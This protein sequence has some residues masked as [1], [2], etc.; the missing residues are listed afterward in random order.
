MPS[1]AELVAI[2]ESVEKKYLAQPG[3]TGIDVGYKVVGGVQ[4]D[5]V[6]I[7]VHVEEKKK[8]VP[9]GQQVPAQIDGVVTDVLERRYELQVTRAPL[10]VS[11]LADTT[12]YA[13]LEGGISMGPSRAIG[14]YVFAGT[15]G[16]IVTDEASGQKAAVT[17]FHVACVDDGWSVG[18]RQVQ[19]SRVDTGVPPGDEFGAI[20]RAVLSSHVDGAVVSIDAGRTTAQ[21][22]VDIGTVNGTKPAALGMEVRKRGRTTGLTYG[23]V[24]G[25]ALSVSVDYGD[26]L[27]VHVL[28]GQV[29]IATDTTK[30]PLFSD[31]GDS[32]S[33][34]VDSTG[35]VVALLFAGA[36]TN[37]VGNPVADVLSELNISIPMGKSI[38]KDVKD[39]HKDIIKDK[40]KELR[41]DLI[42]DKE[43][44]KE[45]IKDKEL[46]KELIAD[47][48]RIKDI[49]DVIKVPDLPPIDPGDPGDPGPGLPGRGGFAGRLAEIEGRLSQLESFIS[50]DQRPDLSSSA[51][52]GEEEL[53]SDEIA[54]LRAE[55][56]RQ[57]ADAAAAKTDLDNLLG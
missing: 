1:I 16:A 48:K 5:Q 15:L 14:G 22:I 29:S 12:H 32:G 19:P 39:G 10:D 51:F 57:A 11:A 53:T 26:G 56:E 2:K 31:H 6:A 23:S 36:G 52:S 47:G 45:I 41:K 44:R 37:T 21:T 8:S 33:V 4:T 40:D 42:K 34:I 35:A 24:D 46:K 13:T 49:V 30:N 25:L 27:G 50:A 7:R 55:A 9:K 54:A 18:D 38:I 43:L 20:L 28:T 3:V 17:N